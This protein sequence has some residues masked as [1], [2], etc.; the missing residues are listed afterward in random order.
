MN[1]DTQK[2]QFKKDVVKP[3]SNPTNFNSKKFKRGL[4]RVHKEIEEITRV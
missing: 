1:S 3:I 4:K 2:I